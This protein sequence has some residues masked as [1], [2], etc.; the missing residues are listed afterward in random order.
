MNNYIQISF[1]ESINASTTR[2]F[3]ELLCKEI[4]SNPSASEVIVSMST[5]G[6]DVELAIE[7]YNFLRNLDCRV[8]TVNTSFVNSAGIL[9]FLAGHERVCMSASSFYI[10]SVT[11]KFNGTFTYKDLEREIQEMKGNTNKIINL[12]ESNTLKSSTYWKT[13]MHKGVILQAD[14]AIKLGLAHII[15]NTVKS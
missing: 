7:I 5:P 13:M 12:L 1:T 3:I 10:H 2:S 15:R 9:I 8:T 11:K 4:D 14:K 6:G